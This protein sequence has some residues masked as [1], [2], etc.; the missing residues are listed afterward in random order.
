MAQAPVLSAPYADGAYAAGALATWADVSGTIGYQAV[1]ITP[2]RH[3]FSG[4]VPVPGDGRYEWDGYLP[5]QALPHVMNPEK[6]YWATANNYLFPRDYPYPDAQ[7]HTGTEPYRVSRISEVLAAGRLHTVADMMRLQNDD[8]S[9]PARALVPLLRDLPTSDVNVAKAQATLLAWNYVLDK[10]SV[11]A[12]IYEMWQ[13]RIL[14]NMRD[15]M[16]PKEARDVFGNLGMKKILA[17][18]NAPDGGFGLDPIA[19]RNQ[20]LVSSL[21]QAVADLT[22]KLGPEAPPFEMTKSEEAGSKVLKAWP[23]GAP[24]VPAAAEGGAGMATT[25]WPLPGAGCG[26]P[27]PS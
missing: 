1:A 12:A 4:L 27:A 15:L 6:G 2:L 7:H 14:A 26:L 3:N 21:E 11:A 22:K 10:D 20:V 5:I 13:R 8:L 19:G 24:E 25:S 17:W 18:M 16:V 23:V 9:I